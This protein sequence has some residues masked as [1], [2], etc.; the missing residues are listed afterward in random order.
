MN[1]PSERGPKNKEARRGPAS[2][3]GVIGPSVICYTRLESADFKWG[4]NEQ[5]NPGRRLPQSA[6]CHKTTGSS[7]P[8]HVPSPRRPRRR[9]GVS[10]EHLK[11][12]ESVEVE[13]G[14]DRVFRASSSGNRLLPSLHP[15]LSPGT[16][17]PSPEC[18]Q[19]VCRS[20]PCVCCGRWSP[21]FPDVIESAQLSV[22]FDLSPIGSLRDYSLAGPARCSLL[23]LPG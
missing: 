14:A 20:S 12:A 16:L 7:P 22:S 17:P 18:V 2:G 4:L 13:S 15:P 21:R 11:P 8:A 9:P 10:A 3:G 19:L 5:V 23:Y 1:S 6:L